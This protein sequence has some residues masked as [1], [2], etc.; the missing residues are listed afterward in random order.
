MAGV[1]YLLHFSRPYCHA[2]HYL[3]WTEDLQTRLEAHRTG[4]GARLTQVVVE[5]GITLE[6][7]RTWDGDTYFVQA[8]PTRPGATAQTTEKFPPAVSPLPIT[9][10]LSYDLKLAHPK[11]SL[12]MNR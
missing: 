7:A 8:S 4:T 1:V 6:L 12:R 11:L 3:G 10:V 5:Q 2:K 9:E